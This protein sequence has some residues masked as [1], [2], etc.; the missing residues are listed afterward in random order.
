MPI[1][2]WGI[3]ATDVDDFD[4]SKQ[5]TP[6]RGKTPPN[7][8]YDFQIKRMTYTAGTREKNPQL[9]VGLE[10]VP[11]DKSEQQYA[12]YYITDFIPIMDKTQ[13][14]YVPLL[15]ALGITGREFAT[16]TKVDGEG[17]IIK[18]GAWSLRE[19]DMVCARL[20]D[21][22]D[23]SGNPRKEIGGYWECVEVDADEDDEDIPDDDDDEE[24]YDED[25][26][27]F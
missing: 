18:I 1:V 13:W 4:R 15:D 8:V 3:D 25:E 11:R 22:Q 20:K 27:G 9:A 19:C 17:N 21:G 23:Q 6:Y 7:A 2:R 24:Y 26:D 10:L 12:G 5:F 14:R 16:K